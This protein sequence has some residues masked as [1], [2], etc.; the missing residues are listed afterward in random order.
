MGVFRVVLGLVAAIGFLV[1]SVVA[2]ITAIVGWVVVRD[3]VSSGQ[4]PSEPL[5]L[6][7]MGFPGTL[8]GIP[9]AYAG[10]ILLIAVLV[11]FGDGASSS[12]T[13]GFAD[14]DGGE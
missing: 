12:S 11:L 10:G 7:A 14:G 2:A 4:L 13:G 5:G 6:A 9:T 3:M 8:F 1:K